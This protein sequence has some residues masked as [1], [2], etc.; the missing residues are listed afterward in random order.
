MIIE[1]GGRQLLRAGQSPRA[2]HNIGHHLLAD[3]G[4]D[5]AEALEVTALGHTFLKAEVGCT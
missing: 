3:A 4:T 1:R 5:A 2:L